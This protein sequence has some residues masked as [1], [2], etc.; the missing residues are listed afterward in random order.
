MSDD[1]IIRT[2]VL[3]IE[4]CLSFLAILFEAELL[5][6]VGGLEHASQ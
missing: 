1:Q 4:V 6:P 2:D 3:F 5:H